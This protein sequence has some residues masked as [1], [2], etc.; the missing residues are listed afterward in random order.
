MLVIDEFIS[1]DPNRHSVG[2]DL[3]LPY[4]PGSQHGSPHSHRHVRDCQP[5]V[6][7]NVTHET[8]PAHNRSASPVAVSRAFVSNLSQKNIPPA[9]WVYGH[10]TVVSDPLR[11]VSVL[12]PGGQGGCQ[13]R[14]LAQVSETAR[15]KKCLYAQNG[16]FFNTDDHS[17]L[18]NVV[19]DGEMVQESGGVQNAQFG[20][21][22]D[23]TLVFG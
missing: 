9:R 1:H 14:W 8:W 12:E 7:G 13:R 2:D 18:G 17:C 10:I 16:G 19:S 6:H 22:K 15:P 5:I 4:P 20:I 23:G 11:T 21:R 3:L